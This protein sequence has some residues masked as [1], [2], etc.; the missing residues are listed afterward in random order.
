MGSF[1]GVKQQEREYG[2]N[3][4]YCEVKERVKLHLILLNV[5]MALR[6]KYF[7]AGALALLHLGHSSQAG[8]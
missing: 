2:Q 5:F 3:Y 7:Q 1:L 4:V 8:F 6:T